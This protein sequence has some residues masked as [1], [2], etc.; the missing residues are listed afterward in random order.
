[1]DF[2]LNE[3]QSAIAELA[4]KI[5]G[6]LCTP[7]ALRTHEGSGDPYHVRAWNELAA[8]DLLGVALPEAAGGGGYG[9]LEAAL[10]A[11]QVGRHVAPVPYA[12]TMAAALAL[13]AAAADADE[14]GEVLRTVASGTTVLTV[15]LEGPGATARP[16]GESWPLS[17]DVP[18]V[19]WV[20]QA[21]LVLVPASVDDGT[22]ALFAVEPSGAGV[23][24]VDE[25]AL[26]GL[27]Q[28][29]LQL[30]GAPARRIGGADAVAAL[31]RDAT[32]LQCATVAGVCEGALRLTA[33]YVTER[34]Q[35]GTKIGT[36][37][38]VGQRMADAYIDT[39]GVHLTAR[40]AAWRLSAGMPAD[41]ELHIAKWW[42]ATGGHRV[43]HAAQHLH[44]GVGVD[45]DYAVHRYFRWA[46]VLE[47]QLGSGTEHLRQLGA[48]LATVPA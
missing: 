17:G 37:Q 24:V 34:E 5:L 13:V 43:V 30:A 25:D 27:P 41:E 22:V 36:F 18:F 38:A 6:D 32:A 31:R 23:G 26:W 46:K 3:E 21:R 1:M 2:T 9:I 7:E 42:A 4:G 15:A 19:R 28:G 12:E 33:A 8:S 48:R 40:Q 11:E 39:Q 44:G 10:V 47:L 14:C 35:F 45:V 20:R 29:T 16:D